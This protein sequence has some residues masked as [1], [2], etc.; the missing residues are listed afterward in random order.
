MKKV[1]SRFMSVAVIALSVALLAGCRSN[2]GQLTQVSTIN[3]LMGGAYQGQ[4]ACG[5]LLQYGDCGIGTFD[6]LDGEMII[7]DGM[8]YQIKDDGKVY[9]PTARMTTPFACV[10]DF[11]STTP[12]DLK[13]CDFSQFIKQFDKMYADKHLFYA[14]R[15]DGKFKVVV[16][17]S[18]PRQYP[19]Y[20]KLVDV[21][22][23]Q[24]EFTIKNVE[25]TIFGFRCPEMIKGLNVPGYHLHFI[26]KDRTQ[27]GHVLKF[28]LQSGTLN[29]G[30]YNIFKMILPKTN[31][32]LKNIDLSKD[33]SHDIEKVEK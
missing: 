19:P 4:M 12:A 16:T 3:A 20:K 11:K 9:R 1:L 26:S 5:E 33:R 30:S 15:I 7:L 28:E 29:S 31:K 8:V 10:V 6:A 32:A 22:K 21:A 18:V 27:G 17:R 25:G 23:S 24:K 13:P 2:T 14:I